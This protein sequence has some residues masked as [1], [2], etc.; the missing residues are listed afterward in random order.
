MKKLLTKIFIF[1]WKIAMIN[2]FYSVIVF[3]AILFLSFI[4]SLFLSYFILGFFIK[5]ELLFFFS[6][7]ISLG[8]SFIVTGIYPSIADPIY[9]KE[10]I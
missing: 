4:I 3:V 1:P 10:N 5:G 8:I 9:E 7:L 6:F 2:E